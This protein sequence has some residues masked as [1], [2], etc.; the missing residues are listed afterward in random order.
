MMKMKSLNGRLFLVFI[1]VLTPLLLAG[2]F[3]LNYTM[4]VHK[5][6]VSSY[7]QQSMD[8]LAR[9]LDNEISKIQAELQGYRYQNTAPLAEL[10]RMPRSVSDY[11]YYGTLMRILNRFQFTISNNRLLKEVVLYYPKKDIRLSSKMGL[12]SVDMEEYSEIIE[13]LQM[14]SGS[15]LTV[16]GDRVQI[17]QTSPPSARTLAAIDY[18]IVA[19]LSKDKLITLLESGLY[20]EVPTC[21]FSGGTSVVAIHGDVPGELLTSSHT[22]IVQWSGQQY[23]AVTA[24]CTLTNCSILKL[25][26]YNNVYGIYQRLLIVSI[27]YLIL[28][29]GF[30]VVFI[31][32]IRNMLHKPV[33][34]L[35][36][37][38]EQVSQGNLAV[39]M[40][41][42]HR[43]T[44]FH[45]LYTGF[46][47][48][49]IKLKT[50]NERILQ[51]ELLNSKM[52]LK[53]LQAQINPHFLYNAFFILKHHIQNGSMDSAEAM[54]EYMGKFF[55][56]ITRS[57][58]E[59][60]SFADEYAHVES[61][62][63]IQ[64]MRFM[65]R[66]Q[67]EL[68]ALPEPMK[69]LVVPRLILQPLI[70][71]F[72]AHSSRTDDD[73][74]RMTVNFV[75]SDKSFQCVV[76]DNGNTLTKDQIQKMHDMLTC[77]G[78]S[79]ETTGMVNI[80]RRLQLRYGTTAGLN[81]SMSKLGG[82]KVV[83]S[84]PRDACS[85]EA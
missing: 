4:T 47:A 61:F 65:N 58:H 41:S 73:I 38:F 19:S 28:S 77:A 54:S 70:E 51:Q 57:G 49:T 48:M 23:V 3:L 7:T 32:T 80:H 56:Y 20:P 14:G 27:F 55:Q 60:S 74:M 9:D 39:R 45:K 64:K 25:L 18:L 68:A 40:P 37:G 76:E 29:I 67:I 53:Q 26:P 66:I 83:M 22:D 13:S 31:T 15:I 34:L 35:E 46:N 36:R 44:D 72:F 6:N 17:I 81:V 50:M 8:L 78:S 10:V 24:Q 79:V 30:S 43:I 59:D 1:L 84:I 21:L 71:N 16:T 62:L 63:N 5:Q 42:A 52:E 11:T 12:S 2:V 75:L 85:K 69:S 82:L 33:R